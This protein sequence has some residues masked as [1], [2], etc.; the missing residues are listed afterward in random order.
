MEVKFMTKQHKIKRKDIEKYYCKFLHYT[1]WYIS[2][3]RQSVK[4]CIRHNMS[5]IDL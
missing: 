1:K 4:R 3:G 5:D 2:L